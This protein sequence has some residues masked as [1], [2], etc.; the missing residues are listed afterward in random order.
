MCHIEITQ[1]VYLSL[2]VFYP[3]APDT[4]LLE[5]DVSLPHMDVDGVQRGWQEQVLPLA[6]ERLTLDSKTQRSGQ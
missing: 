5:D 2:L 6:V 4:H 3:G 1:K